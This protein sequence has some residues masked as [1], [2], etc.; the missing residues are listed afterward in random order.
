MPG[1]VGVKIKAGRNLP[2]MD[3]GSDT[4]DAYVEIKLGSV[5][6]KTDVCRKTLNPQ[7]NTDW[8]RFEVDDAELQDEPLQIRLM[9]HDTYS[10]NDAIGK[11]NIS[12]NPL[13]LENAGQSN[14]GKGAVMSGWIPVFDTMHGIRGEVNIIVKVDLFSD[15]NKFRQSSCG[16]QFFHSPCIPHGYRAQIIHGFV[17]ELVVNDD[18]E[19]QW[20]DKIRTPRASNEARQ[21][22]FLKLSGQVQRKIGLKAINLGANA[23]I[24]YT[25]CF[26]LEGDVGVVARGIGTAVTLIKIQ[27]NTNQI[28][29]DNALIEERTKKYLEFLSS[30]FNEPDD[31]FESDDLDDPV[32]TVYKILGLDPLDKTSARSPKIILK[33]RWKPSSKDATIYEENPNDSEYSMQQ[34]LE[35]EDMRGEKPPKKFHHHIKKITHQSRSIISDKVIHLRTKRDFE[36]E[37]KNSKKNIKA[38]HGSY[39]DLSISE[40]LRSSFSDIRNLMGFSKI[41]NRKSKDFHRSVSDGSNMATLLVSSVMRD[42]SL[43]SISEHQT[44]SKVI[45]HNV[46]EINLPKRNDLGFPKKLAPIGDSI[47]DIEN[48]NKIDLPDY[49]QSHN[50]SSYNSISSMSG[51]CS[52]SSEEGLSDEL[53]EAT[54]PNEIIM[55]DPD[56]EHIHM[57]HLSEN[58]AK[59]NRNRD[60]KTLTES[61]KPV[62]NEEIFNNSSINNNNALICNKVDGDSEPNG[63]HSPTK[64]RRFSIDLIIKTLHLP[65]HHHH[66]H[67]D[68]EICNQIDKLNMQDDE[69][70][71]HKKQKKKHR[72]SDG[73]L[74]NAMRSMLMETF[75]IAEEICQTPDKIDCEKNF[76]EK[77]YRED[78]FISSNNDK[79]NITKNENSSQFLGVSSISEYSQEKT[80]T[81]AIPKAIVIEPSTPTPTPSPDKSFNSFIHPSY[82]QLFLTVNPKITS[83]NKSNTENYNNSSCHHLAKRNVFS[84]TC[85]KNNN[86]CLLDSNNHEINNYTSLDTFYLS[87]STNKAHTLIPSAPSSIQ[88]QLRS[89]TELALSSTLNN[90]GVVSSSNNVVNN[91]A[92]SSEII[93]QQQQ[94]QQQQN[95]QSQQIQPNFQTTQNQ[96][97]Q[98]N[99]NHN[100]INLNSTQD[101]S[102]LKNNI[103]SESINNHCSTI[104]QPGHTRAESV[105]TKISSPVKINGSNSNNIGSGNTCINS[106]TTVSNNKNTEIFRR[107][108]DSDLSVTPKGNSICVASDRLVAATTLMRLNAPVSTKISTTAENIDMLE[109][110]FLTMAKYPA[111]F[112]LHIGATVAARSVKLLERVP[113]LDE[114]ETRDSW[115]TEIRMEIRSH[116]RALGCNVI[117]GYSEVTTI[118]DDV[119]VLSATGTAAVINMSYSGDSSQFD[120]VSNPKK[121]TMTVSSLDE[122]ECIK[123]GRGSVKGSGELLN[124]EISSSY[125]GTTRNFSNTILHNRACGMCHIPYTINSVPVSVKMNK[126][127]ICKRGKVPDVLMATIE[128]PECLQITGRG[129]FM[130]AQV[131]RAK[132]DLRSESNAKEI[133][134]GLPFLEYELHRLLINKLKAKGMNAIFGLKT[135]IAVGEKMMALIATGTAVFLTSLPPPTVPKI[136]AGNSWNDDARLNDLQKSL[137]ETV[138]KNREIYQLKSVDPD[139]QQNGKQSDTDE[140]DDELLELDLNAGNKDTCVLEVD[141]IEDLEIIKLLMEPCPPEGFHIVNTQ[142]V[143]GLHDMEVVRNL[144]MFT[145]VWRAKIAIG[146]NTGHFPKHFQRLLQTIYFKLRTMIPCAVC[147]LKFQLGLPESDEIQILVTGMTLGLAEPKLLKQKRKTIALTQHQN[148]D[149]CL[150]IQQ[151]KKAM[152]DELI[153]PLDEDNQNADNPQLLSCPP[154]LQYGSHSLKL[155]KN[156]PSR[157]KFCSVKYSRHLPLHERYGVDITPLS[158]IPGGKIEKYLGNLNFFFIRE[159]T[160]IR[161]NGGISGFVHGFITEL[162]AVVRSHISALG[163]NAMVSFYMTELILVD[164]QHK[165]QGQC[166]ISIGGDVVYVSYYADD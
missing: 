154:N 16:V 11:V 63:V 1:K 158:Y 9:D 93:Q 142:A 28:V 114:P 41:K 105:G 121:D 20:I 82:D 35:Q 22:V 10:A 103:K 61:K 100:N 66:Q 45:R 5:T 117:L 145:Q 146:Q 59:N 53:S 55:F 125:S 47:S 37:G 116:A 106:A 32:N 75:N 3:R 99:N 135:Q 72:H 139:I 137:Q 58:K 84:S 86:N 112:I 56:T 64:K 109:Y 149:Q 42:P 98:Q 14:Q 7:W 92:Q 144:Q 104:L 111:G 65:I 25:Q 161:E 136:V 44:H 124:K 90:G 83:C 34:L 21:V 131:V 115:W 49:D 62:G 27:E 39:S 123:E 76:P 74:G 78:N 150:N 162:L 97:Q 91:I 138:E 77:T 155:K 81:N 52:S 79:D 70:D 107:S 160:S 38:L 54:T 164:N 12:L 13:C 102:T 26:D 101:I 71:K 2:V 33:K 24:G 96:Q 143:P 51:S 73:L 18:P 130:Q 80:A 127:A 50:E 94:Q 165:N 67:D 60:M 4:T 148:S 85:T 57:P 89:S 15:V 69:R 133:S 157:T 31:K 108:S 120:I 46:N 153:F 129:C 68:Q 30:S 36:N 23:V 19:Y 128:I 8:F 6:H 147:D 43:N 48:S 95:L 166:L 141:D 163:G 119:C 87:S 132:K 140:S 40:S 156:S 122:R 134:D 113:N 159:S 126:C 118:S 110:P 151:N 88:Q 152:D 17:E 29:V